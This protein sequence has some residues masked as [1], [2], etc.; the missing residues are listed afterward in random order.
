MMGVDWSP[1][2]RDPRGGNALLGA[3]IGIAVVQ[4]LFVTARFFTRFIQRMKIGV[5]DYLILFA[6]LIA[7]A[8]AKAGVVN[9]NRPMAST[10][11]NMIFLRKVSLK[12]TFNL[13]SRTHKCNQSIF[14]LQILNYPLSLTSSKLAL[15][16]FYTRIFTLRKFRIC[17]YCVGALVL[18]VGV[19][20]LFAA[21][22]QCT[23]FPYIWNRSIPGGSCVWRISIYRI[24]S[25]FNVLTGVLIIILPIPSVWKLHAPRGQKVALTGVSINDPTLGFSVEL[26]IL[27]ALES[28]IVIVASC[29]MSIWPLFTKLVPQRFQSW[30]SRTPRKSEHQ[31]W[32]LTNNHT[33]KSK[34]QVERCREVPLIRE[35]AWNSSQSS[36]CSLA[37]LEDQ[38]LSILVDD[39]MIRSCVNDREEQHAKST[40]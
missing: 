23:P 16:L 38:R 40:I 1:G 28:G 5:D 36:P 29:L 19:G 27:V 31:N 9:P 3:A 10:P 35:D 8:V 18:G 39:T 34:T 32:Y 4:I 17:A 14:I 37:D 30:F 22:F 15:L 7:C 13:P 20:A 26:G 25:P 2:N 6:L 12:H 21:F 24:L 11:E 33:N